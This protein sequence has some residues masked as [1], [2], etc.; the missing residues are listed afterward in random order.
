MKL[1]WKNGH[2]CLCSHIFSLK[3]KKRIKKGERIMDRIAYIR[4]KKRSM[5]SKE[6]K[7]ENLCGKRILARKIQL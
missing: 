5:S 7:K 2:C 4:V 3:V 6:K 1:A